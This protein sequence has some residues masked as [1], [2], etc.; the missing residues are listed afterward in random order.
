[1]AIKRH[2]SL[3]LFTLVCVAAQLTASGIGKEFCLV[4]LTMAIYYGIV[5]MGLCIVM[6]HAGQVSLGH[7][8]FFALGGYT[9]AVMTT[10][11]LSACKEAGWARLLQQLHILVPREDLFGNSILT[12]TPWAAFAMAMVG[13]AVVA[14]LIGYPAL[15]LKGHYLAMATLG[16]GVIVHKLLLSSTLTGAADGI[17]NV[18]EWRL[19]LGLVVC[20]KSALR[21]QNYYIA[22]GLALFILILLR[23]LTQSR[24]GRALHAI[25]EREAAAN[26]IGINTAAYKLKAFVFSALLAAIAGV[27]FTHFVGSIGPAEAATMRSVRYV[28]LAAVGGMA[29]L[30]GVTLSSIGINYLSLRDWFGSYDNAV[31][32]AILII[33]M[34]VAPDGPLKPLGHLARRLTARGQAATKG[35]HG[36]S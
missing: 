31:F 18:P 27:F 35:E 29:S 2:V 22:C 21:V 11:D 8:A 3:A 9:S 26:A 13:T 36:A 16:F 15:R 1:M 20:G 7:G 33:I 4:Q 12:A 5:V 24:V 23:N 6:G 30:W 19:G 14:C 17:T 28:A 34:S 10:H 25:H 32:G